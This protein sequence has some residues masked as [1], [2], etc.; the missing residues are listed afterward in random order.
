[1]GM[2]YADIQAYQALT[3]RAQAASQA[4]YNTSMANNE[5]EQ[6][7]LAKAKFA[8]QQM[9]DAATL[10]GYFPGGYGFGTT[11]GQAT[12]PNMQWTDTTFGQAYANGLKSVSPGTMTQAALENSQQYGLNQ[13]GVT[14]VYYDPGQMTY[15][16]GTF[17]RDPSTNAIGQIQQNGQL[18]MFGDQGDF[19]RAGG[20]W[21]MV[22]NPD[23]VRNVD[24]ATYQRLA[25]APG[26]NGN[27]P[28]GTASLQM[29]QMYG[30]YGMPT[31]GA[32]TMAMQAL[33]GSNA[34]PTANQQTLA[35]QQQ[36]F[37]E[38]A[39]EAGIT[40]WYNAP[41]STASTGANPTP[42]SGQQTLAAQQQY[43]NQAY[44]Q[45][46]ANQQNT[47]AYLQLLSSLR[48]PADWA[49]YQQVL[50]STPNGMRDLYAAAM[51]QYVPGGGATTGYQPQAANLNTLQEQVGGYTTNP[52]QPQQ[53]GYMQPGYQQPGYQ[54]QMLA[55][56]NYR[57][58]AMPNGGNTGQDPSQM[59]AQT[60]GSGLGVGTGNSQQQTQ[61]QYQQAMGN[62]TNA[63]GANQQYNLPAPNQIAAQSWNNM[64]PSQQQM[65]QGM[66][67]ANGWDKQDVE[68]LRQQALPKYAQNASSAG[69]W[70]LQ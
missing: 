21:D 12:L 27:G 59:S 29:Q 38:A 66:Y 70:R 18:R 24:T 61:T 22:N 2:T 5:G 51:G 48:G 30:T 60:W 47:Q 14:G 49:K 9:N 25:Q 37:N 17:I 39:T 4:A 8:W 11:A 31:A 63:Y 55:A 23:M 54:N 15:A 67:E 50:G 52:G 68:A 32:P 69:T 58:A 36:Y 34:A 56:G 20:S 45:S 13:A 42:G 65:L 7:A 62:G 41:S 19:L 1:M 16:P 43:W 6:T 33:Y 57:N 40:G 28:G 44:Q 26:Q 64:T 35:A 10:S 53:P 3:Q 46:Q